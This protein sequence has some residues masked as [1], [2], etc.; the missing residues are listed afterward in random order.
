MSEIKFVEPCCTHGERNVLR[1][2]ACVCHQ[3]VIF[4]T[5]CQGQNVVSDLSS[6]WCRRR[7]SGAST[8]AR[9][10]IAAQT[11][12]ISRDS[13]SSPLSTTHTLRFSRGSAWPVAAGTSPRPL[14]C[15]FTKTA[16]HDCR[17][18]GAYEFESYAHS[19]DPA[20]SSTRQAK[21]QQHALLS[22]DNPSPPSCTSQAKPQRAGRTPFPSPSGLAH[23]LRPWRRRVTVTISPCTGSAPSR[24]RPSRYP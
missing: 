13:V 1:S 8:R 12:T 11:F 22:R 24:R 19:T 3:P 7:P 15:N 17:V 23:G 6:H 20:P 14:G 9:P 10:N 5:L 2:P 16:L 4:I 18:H 21:T